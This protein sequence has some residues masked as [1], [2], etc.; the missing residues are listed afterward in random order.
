M[1]NIIENITTPVKVI[2]IK[3]IT[4]IIPNWE[5]VP[6]GTKFTGYI[7]S[8]LIVDGRI[9]KEDDK[10]YL[11]QNN[12]AGADTDDKLDY[13]YSW[14]IND[15]S[16]KNLTDEDVVI[17]TLTLDPD[18]KPLP[19]W[20]GNEIAGYDPLIKKG[21]VKFGCKTVSNDDIRKLTSMLVD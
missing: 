12:Q 21:Y 7:K 2:E 13:I 18:F 11:C 19:T 6:V 15:G 4:G 5:T 1:I 10:I 9:Q 16:Y 3:E 17:L 20:D 8:N 14:N